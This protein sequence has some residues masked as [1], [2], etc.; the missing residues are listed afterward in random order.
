MAAALLL[1]FTSVAGAAPPSAE[2]ALKD[3]VLGDPNAPIEIVEYSSLTCSHCRHFHIDILPDLKKNYLDTGRAKLVYRDFPFDQLGLMAAIMA[4]CAPPS[5]YFQFLDVLFQNQEKWAQNAD[6]IRALTR[7]G[8]LGGLSEADFRAC[9]ENR[10]IVDGVLQTR[11][12]AGKR[13]Q[14]NSTPSFIINGEKRVVGS[15]PYKVFDDLLKKL[16]K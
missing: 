3:R 6:P 7:I 1:V 11:L 14:V 8:S 12:E 10:T 16:E 5:R 2:E 15:Q 4:R 13:Y 9:T